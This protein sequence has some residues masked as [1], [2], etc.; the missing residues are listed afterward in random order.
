MA[1]EAVAVEVT[2]EAAPAAEQN[3]GEAEGFAAPE[4]PSAFDGEPDAQASE[5]TDDAGSEQ[6]GKSEV[7]AEY[8]VSLPDGYQLTEERE[9][10][11]VEFAQANGFSNE[12]AQS[13]VD[14]Y[15]KMHNDD[16]DRVMNE[17]QSRSSQWVQQSKEAG[18]MDG[19]VL[20]QA[21]AGLAAVDKNGDLGQ[22]LHHLGLDHHPGIIEAFRSHGAA[23]SPADTVPTSSADG[24]ARAQSMA[25]RMYPTMFNQEE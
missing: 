17:W 4:Q 2:E 7:P 8:E 14:L 23:V 18:L 15:L 25:E 3:S 13:A 20:A 10:A 5:A 24:P 9:T 6:E 16:A 12:Q 1:E 21:K 11:F 19:P 22:T